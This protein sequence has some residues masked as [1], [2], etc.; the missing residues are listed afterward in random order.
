MT[1]RIALESKYTALEIS[2][3][4]S[5]RTYF[6]LSSEASRIRRLKTSCPSPILMAVSRSN[7][8]LIRIQNQCKWSPSAMKMCCPASFLFSSDIEGVGEFAIKDIL[9]HSDSKVW[10]GK[11]FIIRFLK[12]KCRKELL[13]IIFL[14]LHSS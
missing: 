3:I 5:N 1:G 7:L 6:Q 2:H 11:S 13:S 12:I 4:D 8:D 9:L 14:L 10:F